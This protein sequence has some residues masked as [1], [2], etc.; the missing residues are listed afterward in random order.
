MKKLILVAVFAAIG[1]SAF[2]QTSN[3]SLQF[4]GTDDYCAFPVCTGV[5]GSE[6]T[7]EGW[8]KSTPSSTPQVVLMAFQDVA[9]QNA[10][11]TIE[12]RDDGRMRFN[13]RESASAVGG[14][15]VFTRSRVDNDLWHHFAAV[16]YQGIRLIIYIDG[17]P[18]EW[19][20]SGIGN[21]TSPPVFELGRNK[22]AGL[23]NFRRFRGQIDDLKIWNK[24]K[25]PCEVLSEMKTEHSGLENGLFANY[26]FD[27]N[28]DTLYDCST[29]KRHGIRAGSGGINNK[30]QF[31]TNVPPLTD[32]DCAVQ[33]VGTNDDALVDGNESLLIN[34]SPNPF[35]AEILNVEI[36]TDAAVH[37]QIF[38]ASGQLLREQNLQ[39]QNS[40]LDMSNLPTGTYVL[41]FTADNKVAI[42]KITKL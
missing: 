6:F 10:N 37:T 31:S 22:Y 33:I 5:T 24:A 7:I 11:I 17:F 28:S 19:V 1:F 15:E 25:D 16:K 27:I 38:S 4:D 18:E 30:P 2:A 9:S 12:V 39:G 20:E 29:N 35:R 23:E 8:F 14:A 13:Y 42:E 26:K 36:N 41:R 21:I 32:I 3:Y 34:I 40:D